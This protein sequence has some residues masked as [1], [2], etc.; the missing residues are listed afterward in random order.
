MIRQI[1]CIIILIMA[2]V[3]R[4]LFV[5][6][7]F[8]KNPIGHRCKFLTDNGWMKGDVEGRIVEGSYYVFAD[9]GNMWRTSIEF[10]R[11]VYWEL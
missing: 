6:R 10:M 3:A 9:D 5:W 7:Q 1:I 11:P 8:K 4:R 2:E